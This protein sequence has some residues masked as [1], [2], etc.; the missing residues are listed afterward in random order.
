MSTTQPKYLYVLYGYDDQEHAPVLSSASTLA[1]MRR[2]IRECGFD[3]V[4]YRY[5]VTDDGKAARNGQR[6][7]VPR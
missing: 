7:E 3:G 2:D 6:I 1:S 5:D 4:V